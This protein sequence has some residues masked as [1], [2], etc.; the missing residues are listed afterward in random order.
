MTIVFQDISTP[1]SVYPALTGTFNASCDN[2]GP[3]KFSAFP[4]NIISINENTYTV[5]NSGTVVVTASQDEQYGSMPI[6]QC[7]TFV[8]SNQVIQFSPILSSYTEDT[9]YTFSAST[10]SGLPVIFTAYPYGIVSID[11][12][13]AAYTVF[14]DGTVTF[15]AIQSG[16]NFYC[17]TTSSQTVTFRSY[18]PYQGISNILVGPN[19]NLSTPVTLSVK[20]QNENVNSIDLSIKDI[21]YTPEQSGVRYGT[22]TGYAGVIVEFDLS[23]RKNSN[24]TITDFPNNPLKIILDLPHAN[25]NSTLRLHNIANNTVSDDYIT[26]THDH[27]TIWSA[28]VSKLPTVTSAWVDAN[29]YLHFRF[30]STDVSGDQLYDYGSGSYYATLSN[31]AIISTTDYVTGNGS[32]LLSPTQQ[33]YV[34]VN[35][36]TP[37]T[38]GLT[39]S[40]WFKSNGS[41]AWARIFDFGNGTAENNFFAAVNPFW[42]DQLAVATFYNNQQTLN[43]IEETMNDNTWRHFVW[44]L[45]YAPAGSATSTFTIYINGSLCTI[46]SDNFYPS[47]T[48]TQNYIG[49]SHWVGDAAYNGLIDDFRIYQMTFQASDVSSLFSKTNILQ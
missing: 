49:K 41:G 26:L 11:N 22:C 35:S 39:I 9:Q 32:L 5:L 46:F 30:S 29:A 8:K 20:T 17:A 16:D 2:D 43:V 1:I 15:N 24:D 47:Q 18:S 31:S 38:N 45:T 48:T 37:G 7:L 27:G 12:V 36:F 13:N 23:A 44:V 19:T 10:S 40:F 6:S 21:A 14:Q 25:T 4:S 33:S 28:T 3:I 42:G 34:A